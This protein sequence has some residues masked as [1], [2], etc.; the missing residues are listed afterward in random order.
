[1][2]TKLITE[3]LL[4]SVVPL[5]TMFMGG[6]FGAT[7]N[8]KNRARSS[9]LHLAAGVVFAVV[10]I[11]LLP[12]IVEK[13]NVVTVAIGFFAGLAIMLIIKHY[14][15]KSEKK[16]KE[17]ISTER[18]EK[19]NIKILPWGLLVGI[20]IDIILDGILL[21]VGFSAGK[22]EGILLCVALSLEV[23]ALGL[24]VSTELKKEMF[25]KRLILFITL[26]LS[27][28]I[29]VGALIGSILLNLISNN[30]LDGVLA[31]GL[32][33]LMYLVTEELLVEAHEDID[34]PFS[35]AIFFVGFFI[36]LMIALIN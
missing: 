4:F 35:T 31:F 21:G 23:L 17:I 5:I 22:S 18:I 1:M 8:V 33:A 29:V 13:Q 12:D 7:F 19:E 9:F 28:S 30:I 2:D 20:A 32:A 16:H 27:F 14:T 24:V 3:I 26:V 15:R 25:K 10:A 11:E 34:T 36:F 6:F